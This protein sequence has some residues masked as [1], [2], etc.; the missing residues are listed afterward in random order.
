MTRMREVRWHLAWIGVLVAANLVLELL[1]DEWPTSGQA[2]FVVSVFLLVLA[3]L[4][5]GRERV[6]RLGR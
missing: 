6:R 3:I 5:L 2:A 1:G 4:Q